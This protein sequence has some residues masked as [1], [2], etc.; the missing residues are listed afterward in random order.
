ML[1]QAV[2]NQTVQKIGGFQV[3]LMTEEVGFLT[4]YT[5]T[6]KGSHIIS[7]PFTG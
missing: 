3:A 6:D 1:Q 7:R 2:N 4:V 5:Y